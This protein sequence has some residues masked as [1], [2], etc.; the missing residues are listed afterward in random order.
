[1]V[2][3]NAVSSLV[4]RIFGKTD[5]T[6]LSLETMTQMLAAAERMGVIDYAK[7]S[8]VKNIFRLGSM[9]VQAVMTHRIDVFSLDRRTTAAEAAGAATD[10]LHSRFPVYDGDAENV[11]GVVALKRVLEEVVHGRRDRP[12]GRIMWNPC[13]S[14]PTKSVG[15]LF[16]LLKRKKESFVV[17]DGRVRRA[18]GVV[19]F[20]T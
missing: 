17:V 12:I 16:D 2:A 4:T 18:R 15:E 3:I 13:S 8:M 6:E 1:M 9:T 20:G 11:V 5:R 7:S 19:T 14:L 10:E